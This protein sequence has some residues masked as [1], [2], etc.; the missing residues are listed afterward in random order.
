M[1]GG[2]VREKRASASSLPRRL[3]E[4]AGLGGRGSP[5]SEFDTTPRRRLLSA[6]RL[7]AEI[8]PRDF[9]AGPATARDRTWPAPNRLGFLDSS[10]LRPSFKLS[11]GHPS[12][13]PSSPPPPTPI[14]PILPGPSEDEELVKRVGKKINGKYAL[15]TIFVALSRIRLVVRGTQTSRHPGAA[16]EHP[17]PHPVEIME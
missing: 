10:G 3:S 12:C 16:G 4:E 6:L 11:G 7:D 2:D 15:V 1:V 17:P 8:T 5:S 14:I 9:A 13:S